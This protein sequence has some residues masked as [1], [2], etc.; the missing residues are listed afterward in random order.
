MADTLVDEALLAGVALEATPVAD[1]DVDRYLVEHA[2][3][4]HG[5]P[6]VIAPRSALPRARASRRALAAEHAARPAPDTAALVVAHGDAALEELRDAD[7]TIAE[8]AVAPSATAT[9][10]AGSLSRLYRLRESSRSN[11]FVSSMISSKRRYGASTRPRAA[12]MSSQLRASVQAEAAPV[13][14]TDIDRYFAAEIRRKDPTAA[15]RPERIR[16]YLDF[17]AR[18]AAEER[19]SRTSVLAVA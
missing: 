19:S 2:A 12:S 9:S 15:K 6:A 11:G 17:R 14:D 3:D 7:A 8:V 1:A 18:R 13:S 5:P 4:F 10:S 16:P